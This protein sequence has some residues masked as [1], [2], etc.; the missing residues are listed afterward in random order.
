MKRQESLLSK[1]IIDNI[2]TNIDNYQ[3]HVAV[4]A[5]SDHHAQ[6]LSYPTKN[7]D[8]IKKQKILSN[9]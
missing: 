7:K 9:L 6:V 3:A 4:S 5:L 2:F 8:V 1:T